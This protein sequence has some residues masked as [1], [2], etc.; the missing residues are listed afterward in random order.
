MELRLYKLPYTEPFRPRLTR[1][2]FEG[3]APE[4]CGPAQQMDFY[5]YVWI[6][7][8]VYLESFQAVLA[9]AVTLIYRAPEYLS[10]GRIGHIPFNRAIR[11][12]DSPEDRELILG[13]M[14]ELT[15]IH[16][17]RLMESVVRIANGS[18]L[19]DVYLA[20][21]ESTY[22]SHIKQKALQ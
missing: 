20:K 3:K 21:Q 15:N 18:T 16:F 4:D 19:R 7:D 10:V 17:P 12:S 13:A 6:R 2:L 22:L 11:T 8:K 1:L 5:V 14:Q 9:D